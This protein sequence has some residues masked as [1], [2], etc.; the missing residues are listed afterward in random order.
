MEHTHGVSRPMDPSITI[1]LAEDRWEKSL[2]DITDYRAVVGSLMYPAHA[3]WPDI[4][5]AVAALPC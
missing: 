1:D 4:M 5:Y 2:D 3:T